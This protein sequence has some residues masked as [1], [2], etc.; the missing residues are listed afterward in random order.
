MDDLKNIYKKRHIKMNSIVKEAS[1]ISKAVEQAW[2]KADKPQ[3]FSIRILEEPQ[4]NFFGIT[5]KPAKIALFFE[6]KDIKKE[7]EDKP[8]QK[9][10][11]F[12]KLKEHNQKTENIILEKPAQT[13][14]K[15]FWTDEMVSTANNWM[16]K[17]LTEIKKQNISFS[18]EVKRY[19]LK[20]LFHEP[21]A[22]KSEDQK[23]IFRNFAHLMMQTIRNKFKKQFRY[24]KVVITS[25]KK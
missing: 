24:H 23:I 11:T 19:H 18:F 25:E 14:P 12:Q 16:K 9:K 3:K 10:E 13:T 21:I 17:M 1:S 15:K 6:K 20:F 22:N 5:N 4:K 8:K 2:E 7:T